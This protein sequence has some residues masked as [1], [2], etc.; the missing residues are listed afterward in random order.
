MLVGNRKRKLHSKLCFRYLTQTSRF[1]TSLWA[2]DS[3]PFGSHI[4]L[5]GQNRDRIWRCWY[6]FGVDLY[7]RPWFWVLFCSR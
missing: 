3:R 2:R 4:E 1:A 6:A 7:R 5:L